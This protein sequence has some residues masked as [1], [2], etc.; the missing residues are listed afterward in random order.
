[1]RPFSLLLIPFVIAAAGAR[2]GDPVTPD[3]PLRLFN[4]KDLS[5]FHTWLQDTKRDDPRGVFSVTPD[6]LLRISGDG[7]GYLS[8]DKAYRDY[9]LVVE[10]KWGGRN[11]RGRERNARDSGIFLHSAGPDGNSF[12]GSGAFKAAIECQ[13]M[14][15]SVGD[16]LLINGKDADGARIPVGLTASAA[17]KR[18]G[19]GYPIW[20]PNG[21]PVT[22]DGGG[23]L[24]WFGKDRRW[25]DVLDFRGPGDVESAGDEWTRV[26]CVCDGDRITVLVNGVGVNEATRVKPS[27][28]P[29][30]LQCEGSEINF[31]RVELEPLRKTRG[32]FNR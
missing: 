26:E 23:R 29:I 1:M 4:G 20:D 10:F 19:E 15:G 7:F 22:L 2:A 25:Q 5:G 32:V 31:R 27:E 28:G 30:L 14:Q 13:V 24:T 16:L 12:D 18:D 8:T 11:F 3:Q 9:R 21:K 17:P 6:G